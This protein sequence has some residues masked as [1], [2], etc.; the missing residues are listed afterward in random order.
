MG[1]SRAED[2]LP[3][4]AMTLA[5]ARNSMGSARDRGDG[6]EAQAEQEQAGGLGDCGRID[7]AWGRI[8]ADRQKDEDR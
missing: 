4:G 6:P 1:M 2:V 8:A 3:G 5:D 7:R